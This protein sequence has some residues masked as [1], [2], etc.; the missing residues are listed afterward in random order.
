LEETTE[1][2]GLDPPVLVE[3]SAWVGRGVGVDRDRDK[4]REE[5]ETT[6]AVMVA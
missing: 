4:V 3:E 5:I 2:S 1:T 6:A